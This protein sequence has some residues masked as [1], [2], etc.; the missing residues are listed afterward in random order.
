VA[1][2]ARERRAL[3]DSLKNAARGLLEGFFGRPKSD[4]TRR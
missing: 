1:D 4:T 2:P 3:E